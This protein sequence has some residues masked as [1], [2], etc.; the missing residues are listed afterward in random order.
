MDLEQKA[1]DEVKINKTFS[2]AYS[3]W[4]TI[5]DINRD[6]H[7]KVSALD[8]VK[9]LFDKMPSIEDYA[10]EAEYEEA[11]KDHR[12]KEPLP[13]A[14]W[15]YY[16]IFDDATNDFNQV[17]WDQVDYQIR[18]HEDEIWTQEQIEHIDLQINESD[19]YATHVPYVADLYERKRK[20]KAYFDLMPHNMEINDMKHLWKEWT[21]Y[22]GANDPDTFMD[23]HPE[24]KRIYN[25]VKKEEKIISNND[26]DLF[27]L[28]KRIGRIPPY[29]QPE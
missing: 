10:N 29:S 3:F 21:E 2:G 12:P 28:L 8:E 19:Y 23:M 6:Y 5:Q 7:T 18:K 11:L 25:G 24:F 1:V 13:A 14:R 16:K 22:A 15:D 9:N 17:D 4:N 27:D 20:H 26:P